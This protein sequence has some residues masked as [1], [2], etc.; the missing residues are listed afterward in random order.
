VALLTRRK[1]FGGAALDATILDEALDKPVTRAAAELTTRDALGAQIE[2]SGVADAAVK[3][4]VV[5][6]GIA[7]V[8]V[9]GPDRHVR[10]GC[11][12]SLRMDWQFD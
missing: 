10:N 11:G 3:V 9:D 6:D 7:L 2:V 8:A 1:T 4:F 12:N 5:H